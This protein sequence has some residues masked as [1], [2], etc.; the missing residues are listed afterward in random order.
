MWKDESHDNRN[1][2]GKGD[3]ASA[4]E[5]GEGSGCSFRIRTLA[6]LGT[7]QGTLVVVADQLG[8]GTEPV[9][10]W[11]CLLALQDALRTRFIENQCKVVQTV[12]H[13]K[14][15]LRLGFRIYPLIM[16]L[17]RGGFLVRRLHVQVVPGVPVNLLATRPGAVD[18][19]FRTAR[20]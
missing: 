11:E 6:K 13:S 14:P 2:T 8:Y 3:D 9:S 15:V 5:R 20:R 1:T 10:G 18:V 19:A 16:G 17:R 4:F 12:E 7:T